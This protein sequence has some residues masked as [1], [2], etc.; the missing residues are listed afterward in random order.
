MRTAA[1]EEKLLSRAASELSRSDK[2]NS[3]PLPE[4]V[5][6]GSHQ[7]GCASPA[8]QEPASGSVASVLEAAMSVWLILR[9]ARARL[10]VDGILVSSS[11]GDSSFCA[12][13]HCR[14]AD[15][16]NITPIAAFA[17]VALP[18]SSRQRLI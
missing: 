5:S 12:A 7:A 18:Q 1:D 10:R 8:S 15:V 17:P 14:V 16:M 3:P 13:L 6:S 2:S 4:E 9:G 11:E